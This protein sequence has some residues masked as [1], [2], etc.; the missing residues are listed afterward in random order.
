MAPNLPSKSNLA[1]FWGSKNDAIFRMTAKIRHSENGPIFR[2]QMRPLRKNGP[3]NPFLAQKWPENDPFLS[4]FQ[5]KIFKTENFWPKIF[6]Q[7][8]EH[9]KSVQETAV[10][11]MTGPKIF[12]P[13]K[14]ADPENFR[15][16][17]ILT[18]NFQNFENSGI[19]N[20]PFPSQPTSMLLL[21]TTCKF[22]S[23]TDSR[24]LLPDPEIWGYGPSF[25]ENLAQNDP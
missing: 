1:H 22:I 25:C 2:P 13:A 14:P 8:P 3:K 6:S 24:R 5:P 17:K 15:A 10:Q 12:R 9:L 4:H 18:Q 16:G 23:S 21:H 20:F 19:Q 11:A 7:N